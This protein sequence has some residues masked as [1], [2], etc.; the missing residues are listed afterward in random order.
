MAAL[1]SAARLQAARRIVVLNKV[2]ALTADAASETAATLGEASG[3]P[4]LA[5]SGATGR[6][7]PEVLRALRAAVET[8]RQEER[9]GT[10]QPWRP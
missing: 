2:D 7:V 10:G 4:V 1:T 6:G 8:A 5:M 3:R 9:A